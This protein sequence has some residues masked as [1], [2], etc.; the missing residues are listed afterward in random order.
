MRKPNSTG[1]VSHDGNGGA[2]GVGR[3]DLVGIVLGRQADGE[4]RW[5]VRRALANAGTGLQFDHLH[6]A[7]SGSKVARVA[8][9]EH[10][11]A[12]KIH[13]VALQAFISHSAG[14]VKSGDESA[15][16]FPHPNDLFVA[17]L[18]QIQL[19][20]HAN[21]DAA[22]GAQGAA[23]GVLGSDYADQGAKCRPVV[24]D[25]AAD[26]GADPDGI[27]A[28]V[29][30]EAVQKRADVEA[31]A[32]SKIEPRHAGG[33][34]HSIDPD[35][36]GAVLC[37][38]QYLSSIVP[39]HLIH[40]QLRAGGKVPDDRAGQ[41]GPGLVHFVKM[42]IVRLLLGVINIAV[43]VHGHA[44]AE[45]RRRRQRHDCDQVARSSLAERCSR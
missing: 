39:G 37:R 34:I 30:S 8:R 14:G 45:S 9:P 16:A 40:E 24:L 44:D 19:I 43:A 32:G 6:E 28:G 15:V 18:P 12:R 1:P 21:A 23:G 5:R 10:G 35:R 29:V 26:V 13:G 17:V 33:R 3:A 20:T 22:D 41:Q 2:N 36:T 31:L 27:V 7:G 38:P 11:F 42:G 25:G 4:Q